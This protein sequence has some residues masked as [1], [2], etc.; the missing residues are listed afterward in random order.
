MAI[1]NQRA[2]FQKFYY[3]YVISRENTVKSLK[4]FQDDFCYAYILQVC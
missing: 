4:G 2:V 3:D 1:A